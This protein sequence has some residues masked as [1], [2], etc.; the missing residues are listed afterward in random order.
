MATNKEMVAAFYLSYYGRPADIGGLAY[1]T[2]KLD[3]AGGDLGVIIDAF[4]N[5]AEA[6]ASFG[7]MTPT[8]HIAHLYQDLLGR[9][10][11][12][13]DAAY[14]LGEV[15]AGRMTIAQL[16]ITVYNGAQ[17][18]DA[19]TVQV[20]QQVADQFTATLPANGTGYSGPAAIEAARLVI[21]AAKATTS[22]ADIT[23][24]ANAG[25][26]LATSAT[27]SPAVITALTGAAGHLSD[28]MGTAAGAANPL[29]LINL[30]NTIVDTAAGN[31]A[32]LTTL[33]GTGTLT[34]LVKNLPQDV[35][36]TELGSAIDSGG[37]AGGA[38]VV[39]PGGPAG[40]AFVLT[41][42]NDT[43]IGS[44]EDNVFS[45]IFSNGGGGSNTFNEGDTL[46]GGPGVDTLRIG[47][48]NVA[49]AITLDD[50][51]WSHISNIEKLEILTTTDGVQTF[52]LG[53]N[54]YAAFTSVNM[55]TAST[56]GAINITLGGNVSKDIKL[57]TEST[58]GIQTIN[59]GAGAG[60]VTVDATSTAGGLTI[61]GSDVTAVTTKSTG[62]NQ[63]ISV[64]GV[65]S[66]AVT[67]NAES[68]A[69]TQ[70]ITTSTGND[71]INT[72]SSTGVV[73]ISGGAGND[74]INLKT[75]TGVDTIVF[76]GV[77]LADGASVAA[78]VAANGVDTITGFVSASDKLDVTALGGASA[79]TDVTTAALANSLILV[80]GKAISISATGLAAGLTTGGTA[81][82]AAGEWTNTT[83]VAAYL[84]ELMTVTSGAQHNVIVLNDTSGS[85]NTTYVY[86]LSNVGSDTTI[87]AADIALVGTITH[88][89][90]TALLASNLV[91]V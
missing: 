43:Y 7:G 36:L 39:N 19:T 90:G 67:V 28:L 57:T 49:T 75:H 42:A 10:P 9:T 53:N 41:T 2:G 38:A 50:T 4:A 51:Y 30:I 8:Q 79:M 52:T 81:S 61:S 77:A 64:T 47:N 18:T 44:G 89:V 63:I 14:W 31:S 24:L 23:A 74:V 73:S 46:N 5:S 3:L 66:A 27:A 34:D 85:N 84:D 87:D 78:Q 21:Q 29:A 58:D 91:L 1:W 26:K 13:A 68:T 33:L 80:S 37:F 45:G 17:G 88:T 56:A 16:A 40:T 22:A 55:K 35:T 82:I 69:G 20:R 71:V 15:N 83:K 12:A 70:K 62:G 48:Q 86:V 60:L 6:T 11:E 25:A 76:S 32:S 59:A 65:G 72:T 54:F